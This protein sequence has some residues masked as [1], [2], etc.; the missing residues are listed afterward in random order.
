MYLAGVGEI[1]PVKAGQMFYY[2]ANI[3]GT[4][5]GFW[6]SVNPFSSGQR[7]WNDVAK[8]TIQSI[9]SVATGN[10][11]G[12]SNSNIALAVTSLIDR[13][14][15]DDLRGD[16]DNALRAQPEVLNLRASM[17][18]LVAGS[19]GQ[20]PSQSPMEMPTWVWVA[21]GIGLLMLLRK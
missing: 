14:S 12:A 7:A 13:A 18:R 6:D 9:G 8:A 11:T 16:L 3:E 15:Q 5:Q 19:I 2:D 4:E 21:V 1:V 20:P 17:L 10:V